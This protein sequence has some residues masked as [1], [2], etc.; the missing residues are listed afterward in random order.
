MKAWFVLLTIINTGSAFA[1]DPP[2]SAAPA[3]S[4][5][6]PAAATTPPPASGT[7]QAT[8]AN[9]TGNPNQG[10][11]TQSTF[12]PAADKDQKTRNFYQV[13]EDVM[14]DFEYDL[15]NGQVRGV[16]DV[17]IR[18]IATSENVPPSFK[19]QLEILLTERVI[20]NTQS[21]VIQ[22]LPCQSKKATLSGDNVVISSNE[23]NAVELA[24]LAKIHGIASYM[25]VAFSY[26]P[27]GLLLSIAIMDAENSAILWSRSYN[28]ETSRA[29]AFRR[30]VDYTQVDEARRKESYE[31][32]TQYRP[33]LYYLF[34]KDISSYSGMLGLGFRMVERYDNRKKEVGFEINYLL[35]TST[36]TGG[37]ATAT[38]TPSVYGGFN[39]TMLFV[40]AWNFIGDLENYNKP[41]GSIS[42]GLGGTYSSGF[43]GALLRTGYEWRLGKHWAVTAILGYRPPSTAFISGSE[44]G[45]VSGLEFGVG[46]SA[47]L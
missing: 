45:S 44:A 28:S 42:V 36:L 12:A 6:S 43:L 5:S 40:H 34:E 13:L 7:T 14:G 8:T 9:P 2:T 29:E 11:P 20:K 24:R 10:K 15:K 39:V 23:H 30:G 26:Q 27:T 4:A 21:R 38:T 47:L 3:P 46:I 37:S 1:A 19:R 17:S 33:T 31:P 41:R 32:T 35:S 25:D 22:C 16:K 18:A